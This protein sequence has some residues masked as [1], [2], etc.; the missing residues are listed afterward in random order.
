MR[1]VGDLGEEGI[2]PA[3]RLCTALDDMARGNRTRE[4]VVVRGFPA[5]VGRGG[6]DD[7]RRVGDATRHNH[8][9]AVAQAVGDT[10]RPE[11]RVGRQRCAESKLLGPSDQVVAL[12]VGDVDR[13]VEPLG[14][15]PHRDCQPG[16]VQ[17]ARVGDD[18]H[19]A[20]ERRAQAV[21][22]LHQERLGIAAVGRLGAVAGKDQHGQLGEV[23]A[24]QVVQVA[25]GEHL[26]HRHQPVAVEARAVADADWTR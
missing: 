20:I 17:P 23:V 3:G 2:V 13:Q 15:L 6:A 4:R 25:A 5:E 7:H 10:P 11:V 22:E 14:Q 18:A 9:G 26:A 1:Q 8:V 21:L 12:H 19:T 16:G 24:G